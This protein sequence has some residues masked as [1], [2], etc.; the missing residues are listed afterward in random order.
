MLRK[1]VIEPLHHVHR[2]FQASYPLTE[3]ASVINE[4]IFP[5]VII[6]GVMGRMRSEREREEKFTHG[7]LRVPQCYSGSWGKAGFV[8]KLYKAYLIFDTKLTLLL[9]HG[10]TWKNT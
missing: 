5:F 3:C 1:R 2:F 9:L 8:E 6:F 7:I 10:R 4:H